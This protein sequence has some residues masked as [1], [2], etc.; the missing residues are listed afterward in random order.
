MEED[1]GEEDEDGRGRWKL[2]REDDGD[3]DGDG[4][5]GD[6]A[7]DGEEVTVVFAIWCK[8]PE[9]LNRKKLKPNYSSGCTSDRPPPLFVSING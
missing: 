1:D 5:G 2:V 8:L 3:N 7:C 4:G 9:L 6:D